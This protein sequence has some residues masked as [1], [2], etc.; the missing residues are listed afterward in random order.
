MKTLRLHG[1]RRLLPVAAA[2]IAWCVASLPAFGQEDPT[3]ESLEPTL[4]N[5]DNDAQEQ[6]VISMIKLHDEKADAV[7]QGFL[8]RVIYIYSTEP[9]PEPSDEL[10]DGALTETA[11]ET[12]EVAAHAELVFLGDESERDGETFTTMLDA[13]ERQP[14]IA[15]DG[16]ALVV[17]TSRLMGGDLGRRVRKMA[18]E[19]LALH[20]PDPQERRTAALYLGRQGDKRFI[21]LL[22]SAREFEPNRWTRRAI[23]EGIQLTYFA[24]PDPSVRAKAARE[25][26]NLKSA[27]GIAFF[28]EVLLNASESNE[29]V[30][31]AMTASIKGMERWGIVTTIIQTVWNGASLAS[32][33][34]VI[35]LGLGITFGLMRVINMAHGE[36][37]LVGAYTTYVLQKAFASSAALSSVSVLVSIPM[38]FAMAALIGILIEY[39]VVRHLYG[40]PLDTLLATFGISLIMQQGARHLFGAANVDIAS[41]AWLTGGWQIVT[42]VVLPYNRIFI[43]MLSVGCIALTYLVL[44]KSGAGLKIRA[45]TQNREMA[46][47]LGIKTRSV[48][49]WTFAFGSGLAG[50]AGCALSQLGNVGPDLGQTYIVDSFMVVVLGGVGKLAGT[51]FGAGAIGG[52]NK[53]LEAL[54]SSPVVGKVILLLLLILFLQRNPQGIFPAKGRFEESA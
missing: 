16:S 44:L 51:I 9:P 14:L 42:G 47:C 28:E 21:S 37:M 34:A 35:A 22:E 53:I 36:L 27:A 49:R 5:G 19:L 26:G 32:I 31:A 50:V 38:A 17:P 41:P 15:A 23:E 54:T 20:D 2:L 29:D 30:L 45:V 40:R 39:A 13:W 6:A 12:V 48:D 46:A 8:D 1:T 4:I 52:G 11:T 3:W 7:L 43:V 24:D 18:T 10:P 25:L 33:L